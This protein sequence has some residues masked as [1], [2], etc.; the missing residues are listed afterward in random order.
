MKNEYLLADK[1]IPSPPQG[2]R[3]SACLSVQNET[4]ADTARN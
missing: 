1:Y 2:F 3:G 4:V